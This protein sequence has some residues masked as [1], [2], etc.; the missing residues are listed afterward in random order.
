VEGVEQPAELVDGQLDHVGGCR[1]VVAFDGGGDGQKRV[2]EHREGGP[3][4]PGHPAAD[5]VLVQADKAFRGLEALFDAP[6]LPG[7]PDQGGQ[8]HPVRAV[9][10]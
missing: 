2:G 1:C 10:A 6:A 3:A 9:A 7:D 4:V 8:R 5:L